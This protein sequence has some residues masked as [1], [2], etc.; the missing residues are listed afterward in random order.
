[1]NQPLLSI[2]DLHVSFHTLRGVVRAVRGLN[3]EVHAGETVA[4][5]GE[6]GCGKSTLATA[7]LK[8]G[9]R[10]LADD[11]SVV[12]VV[13]ESSPLVFPGY[14]QIKLCPDSAEQLH[15][16]T[17]N[18]PAIDPDKT[19]FRFPVADDYQPE[20]MVLTGIYILDTHK[21]DTFVAEPIRGST[22]FDQLAIHTYRNQLLDDIKVSQRHFELCAALAG[23]VPMYAFKR[24]LD[25]FRITEMVE[26]LEDHFRKG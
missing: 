14:P 1:M 16:G 9:Y 4:L 22:R 11:V 18:L 15:I 21:P 7:F 20:P 5:V 8:S 2:E 13:K 17:A 10:V 19:K 6:S 12:S 26:F 25:H 24:P 23:L 3:L